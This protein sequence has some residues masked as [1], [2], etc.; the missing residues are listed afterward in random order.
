MAR[1]RQRPAPPRAGA[2]DLPP[3]RDEDRPTRGGD[4]VR[5]R[6]SNL[7]GNVDLSYATLEE[8]RIPG[9]DVTSLALRGATLVD[10]DADDV[11][12]VEVIARDA[13]LRRVRIRGGRI[14]TLDLA[15]A[16]IAEL[17]LRGIRIDYLRLAAAEIED[18]VIT[19]CTIGTIDLPRARATRVAFEGS[20]ADE[21]D[22]RGMRATDLDLRGLDAL[23]F[24]DPLA[25][26]GATLTEEQVRILAP[27]FAAAAGIDV[28]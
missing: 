28:Q 2:P 23:S 5:A 12:A 26:R 3:R 18:V 13:S 27:A 21:V 25:L 22:P 1:T 17:E 6:L 7:E 20:R 8:V 19:D 10:V 15:D 16:R 11:R 4:L 14:G 24:L 9:A